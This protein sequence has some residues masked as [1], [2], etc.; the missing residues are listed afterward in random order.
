MGWGKQVKV[1]PGRKARFEMQISR[2]IYIKNYS[3]RTL[4]FSS[5]INMF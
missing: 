5:L 2:I 3:T 1:G 4:L